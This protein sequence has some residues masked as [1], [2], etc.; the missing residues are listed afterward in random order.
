M[1]GHLL[2]EMVEAAARSGETSIAETT[3]AQMIERAEATG[4][5]T[6]LGY[7][8]R[9]KALT[10]AGP[11]AEHEYRTAIRELERSPLKVMTARTRLLFGEWLRRE[12]RRVEARD[13]LRAAYEMFQ[14]MEAD[15]FAERA[16]RELQAAGEPMRKGRGDRSTVTLTTQ[17]TYIARLAGDGYTNS[18]IAGHLFISPRTVE[19]HLGNIY[20]KL[21]VTSRRE[22]RRLR[23]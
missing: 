7:A 5:A 6:A 9:A 10:T 16:R 23:E 18:E 11:E 3:T 2:N 12:N 1:Y 15:S 8:A 4:N 19:W 17:E 21:G 13:E 14:R 22:L 20:G